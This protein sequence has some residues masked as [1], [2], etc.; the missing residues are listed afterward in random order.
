MRLVEVF[1]GG[2]LGLT[3]LYLLFN[4]QNAPQIIGSIAGGTSKI[5]GT[6]QGR[7]TVG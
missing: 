5:F 4:S 1:L 3:A 2:A 7:G 6:L